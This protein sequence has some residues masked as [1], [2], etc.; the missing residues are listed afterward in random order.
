[1]PINPKDMKRIMTSPYRLLAPVERYLLETNDEKTS[2]RDTQHLHPS[3]ICKKDWCPRSSYYKIMGLPEKPES[4]TLQRLNV[5][6]T[7]TMIHEKWQDWLTKAGVMEQAEVPIYDEE[8]RIMGHADGV[9]KDKKGRA[10]LEIKSVGMGTIRFEDYEL[11]LR[12]SRGE[13]NFEGVWTAIKHPFPSHLRQAMLYMYC[14][15]IQ[16]GLI[17]YEWKPTQEVKEFAITYQPEIVEPILASCLSV[18]RALDAKV[19]PER[20]MWLSPDHRV[21]KFCPYKAECWNENNGSTGSGDAEIP[22]Q[23]RIAQ[24]TEG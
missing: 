22:Q 5:F 12:Y 3:E 13:V 14:L 7:G 10:V 11:F 24:S 16:D 20:P 23:V 9:I 19:A 4:F 15:D 21:C 18:V 8:H 17:L 6:A 1:M 2:H